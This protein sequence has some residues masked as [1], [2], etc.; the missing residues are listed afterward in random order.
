[1][2]DFF[3]KKLYSL[4]SPS[5]GNAKLNI[6]FYHR[7]LADKNDN[8]ANDLD[9]EEFDRQMSIL[10]RLFN[11]LSFD[12]AIAGLK[13]GALPSR[14]VCI[15]FDDGYSDSF[16]VAFP[17]L[18]NYNLPAIFFISTGYLNGGCMFNDIIINAVRHAEN[19]K[20]D[21]TELGFSSYSLD[22]TS[23]KRMA[24]KEIL[25]KVKYLPLTSRDIT[26]RQIAERLTTSP[27][28]SNLM[29][30]DWQVK[31]L[32]CAGMEIGAHTVNHPILTN[33][34]LDMARQEIVNGKAYLENL[35]GCRIKYFAYPNGLPVT[36]YTEEHV[37]IL[38]DLGFEAAVSTCIGS[39]HTSSD[40]FQL[41]RIFPQNLNS[42]SFTYLMT[43]NYLR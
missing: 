13:N 34:N 22:S 8:L 18:K 39:A 32:Q 30:H 38:P 40:I 25:R 41:P 23:N 1:M 31:E 9:A 35:L 20:V 19:T 3:S 37:K 26:A 36:D 6:L 33:I 27:L 7:V 4:I 10:K 5:G 12:E 42:K 21:L 11:V 43:K 14:S 24:I 15:T 28:P 16:D 17:I 2:I 29:M